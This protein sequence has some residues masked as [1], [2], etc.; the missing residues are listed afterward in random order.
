MRGALDDGVVEIVAHHYCADERTR[1]TR[2]RRLHSLPSLQQQAGHQ[3]A[4]G[5]AIAAVAHANQC[6]EGCRRSSRRDSHHV[7]FRT[8]ARAGAVSER[9]QPCIFHGAAKVSDTCAVFFNHV[10]KNYLNRRY[11]SC[12]HASRFRAIGTAA[13]YSTNVFRRSGFVLRSTGSAH[14]SAM[15]NLASRSGMFRMSPTRYLDRSTSSTHS[16]SFLVS[17]TINVREMEQS[18]RQM[19]K[20]DATKS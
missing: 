15:S 6:K 4:E 2:D 18:A 3:E 14:P 12:L 1:T 17:R 5:R 9:E 11:V 16:A 13:F 8:V 7:Q 19:P 10:H 20:I